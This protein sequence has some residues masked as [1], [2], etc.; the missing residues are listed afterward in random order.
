MEIKGI[1]YDLE[2]PRI[3]LLPYDA[4][5]EV[6]KVFTKGA[7]KYR[8]HNWEKGLEHHRLFNSAMRHLYAYWSGEDN[9]PEFG[10]SHLA[11]CGC[12]ILMLLSLSL[13]GHG[14]DDRFTN[15]V[16]NNVNNNDDNNQLN[17]FTQINQNNNNDNNDSP[18]TF[19]KSDDNAIKNNQNKKDHNAK[20]SIKFTHLD[21]DIKFEWN[22]HPIYIKVSH[23]NI[24]NNYLYTAVDDRN[25]TIITFYSKKLLN[26]NEIIK[27]LTSILLSTV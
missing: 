3:D 13:R 21:K 25:M 20:D 5:M 6:A 7:E 19:I 12:N 2:K 14:I 15:N 26:E 16:N 9:D 4:L 18:I 11:H 23:N 1:K 8:A 10:I 27:K 24:N 22:N 17:Q